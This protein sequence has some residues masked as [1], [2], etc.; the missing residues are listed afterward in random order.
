MRVGV[1]RVSGRSRT[2]G[3]TL[4]VM[5]FMVMMVVIRM[6]V[7]G[8]VIVR[9][10]LR[11]IFFC[12]VL[13][14]GKVFLAI[15]PNVDLSGRNGAAHDARDLESRAQAKARDSVFQQL[16]RNSGIDERAQKHVATHSG[17]TF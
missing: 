5:I 17:K 14:A 1:G 16:R 12:P 9:G 13:F 7:G 4:V 6:I 2:F 10:G 8:G 15:H 11:R 3:S